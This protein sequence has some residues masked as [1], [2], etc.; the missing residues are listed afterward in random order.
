M[1]LILSLLGINIV[2]LLGCASTKP[3]TEK[4]F[5]VNRTQVHMGTFVSVS[6]IDE[7]VAHADSVFSVF[8]EVED[9]LSSYK[10]D[11]E[12]ARLN[13]DGGGEMSSLTEQCMVLALH[14]ADQTNGHFDPTIGALTMGTYKFGTKQVRQPTGKEIEFAKTKIGY[15]KVRID[16]SKITLSPGMK[17]DF[18]GIGKGFAVDMAA[19]RLQAEGVNQAVIAASGD[20]R[21]LHACQAAIVHPK[22]GARKLASF[23]AATNELAISTSGVYENKGPGNTHHLISTDSGRPEQTFLSVSLLSQGGNAL[24]DGLATGVSTMPQAK[25]LEFLK[26]NPHYGYVLV[27]QKGEVIYN[28][29]FLELVTDLK[30]ESETDFKFREVAAH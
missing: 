20:I 2:C 25:A 15:R 9:L 13:R 30:W 17:L 18:G 23:M 29:R 28:K 24:L 16:G 4:T 22:D 12:V 7:Q 6:L 1:K 19:N 21:C 3:R 10:T 8:R 14:V 27:T 26:R 5:F 11:S